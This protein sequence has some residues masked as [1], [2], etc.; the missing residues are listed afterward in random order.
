MYFD[1]FIAEVALMI[2]SVC[3]IIFSNSV[4]VRSLSISIMSNSVATCPISKAG[5]LNAASQLQR[6]FKNNAVPKNMATGFAAYICFMK[7]VK[8]EEGKSYNI[9]NR[10]YYLINAADVFYF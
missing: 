4:T 10:K 8:E 5:C 7:A 9:L 6:V 1:D 2:N 3:K